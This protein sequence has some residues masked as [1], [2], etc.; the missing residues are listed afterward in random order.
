MIDKMGIW[1]QIDTFFSGCLR[2]LFLVK[3][4]QGV[5]IWSKALARTQS[6]M[7]GFARNGQK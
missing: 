2:K 3:D 5:E 7:K 1:S 6:P 4:S